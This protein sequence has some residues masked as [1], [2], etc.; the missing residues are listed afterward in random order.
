MVGDVSGK[1]LHA[2]MTVA[3]LVG[4]IRSAVEI[5]TDPA[6]ILSGLNRRLHGRLRHGF[7]TCLVIRLDGKGA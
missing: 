6:E 5:T 3:L 7:A 1:G 4:A 2:A